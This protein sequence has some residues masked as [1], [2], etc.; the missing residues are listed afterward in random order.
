METIFIDPD[1]LDYLAGVIM[2]TGCCI[3]F[4]LG[5]NAWESSAK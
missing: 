1:Q 2:M 5:L 4:C 3:C